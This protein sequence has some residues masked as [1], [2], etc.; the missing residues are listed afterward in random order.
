[1]TILTLEG[2][3]YAETAESIVLPPV[4]SDVLTDFV[5]KSK[6]TRR[7]AWLKRVREWARKRIEPA[8]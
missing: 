2:T 3:D 8:P 7:T 4:A 6:T 1:M 5:E